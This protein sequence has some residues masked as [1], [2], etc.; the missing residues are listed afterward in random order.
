MSACPCLAPICAILRSPKPRSPR[1][2][3]GT[4]RCTCTAIQCMRTACCP[5]FP[6]SPHIHPGCEPKLNTWSTWTIIS[7]ASYMHVSEFKPSMRS[8]H[9]KS[10][11]RLSRHA[12]AGC[13]QQHI[14]QRLCLQ[15]NSKE[16]CREGSAY[17]YG[18]RCCRPLFMQPEDVQVI[19][20]CHVAIRIPMR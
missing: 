13:T 2:H 20:Q 7:Q 10:N 1:L 16:T 19:L 14:V 3:Y 4:V 5:N 18:C 8:A 11:W 12:T 9:C 17:I 15:N 6:S